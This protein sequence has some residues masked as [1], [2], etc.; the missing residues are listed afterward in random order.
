M[1]LTENEKKVLRLLSV[2]FNK[3][4]SINDIARGV[5][6]TP[7]GAYKILKKFEK[8]GVLKAKKIANVK[9]YKLNFENEITSRLLELALIPSELEERVKSRLKDVQQLKSITKACIFFG[10]YI[11]S[12]RNP[13]D[14]DVLFIVSKS[15]FSFYKKILEEVRDIS[16]V[17]IHDIVQTTDDLLQN[18]KKNDVIVTEALR[19]GLVLWGF[20]IVVQV[21][22]N[23]SR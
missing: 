4:F 23:A 6:V 8:E 15:K 17:K 2:S 22:K 18:L 11:T 20:E 9:A 21:I 10:S 3:D 7:N 5:F 14:L 13:R 19:N 12:K 1:M 16:P